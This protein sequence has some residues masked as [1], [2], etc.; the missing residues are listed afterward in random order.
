V[1]L[2]VLESLRH[3]AIGPEMMNRLDAWGR[4][5]LRLERHYAGS[6]ASHLGL[7]AI[8]YGRSPLI[9]DA[10]L[11]ART[12]PQLPTSLR[13]SGYET[14]FLTSG[15]CDG[16]R[17]MEEYLSGDAWDHRFLDSGDVWQDRPLRDSRVLARV[18]QLATE[19]SARP[20]FI[21]AFLMS[22]HFPYTFPAEFDLRQ[23]SGDDIDYVNWK[24][25]DRDV[26]KNRYHNAA[27][28]LESEIMR[29]VQA[30]DPSRNLVIVTGDHGESLGEDGALA[31][32]TR[33]SE[34]QLRVPLVM[35]GPGVRAET[36]SA[37]T[38]H[39]DVAPTL[40]HA[41]A[42]RHVPVAHCGGRDLLNG[43]ASKRGQSLGETVLLCPYRWVEPG[44]L[45]LIRGRERMQ[46][47]YRLSE[48]EIHA[49]GYC[50]ES[51]ALELASSHDCTPES[52]SAWADAL[53]QEL[54]RISE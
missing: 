25:A 51:A 41:L 35:V 6:N 34:I 44:E 48:P 21:M 24:T 4:Q 33:G 54:A 52:A 30:L 14:I 16:F 49:V 15:N 36:I 29:T 46:F 7:F 1:V 47:N 22:T 53:R 23:P 20:R 5:G 13:A 42:G 8:L 50:D 18:R 38:T 9:Y 10:T 2:L 37:P 28:F 39:M 12:P 40:L 27:R 11:D 32:C 19:P 17:R 43:D 45:L 3:S 31:H 26:L